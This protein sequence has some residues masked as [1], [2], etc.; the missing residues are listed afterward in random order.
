MRS[1]RGRSRQGL[2]LAAAG[3]ADGMRSSGPVHV[4]AMIDRKDCYDVLELIDLVNDPKVAPSGAVLAFQIESEGAPDTLRGLRQA[5]VHQ[6][7]ASSRDLLGQAIERSEGPR[8]PLDVQCLRCHRF[9]MRSR[10]SSRDRRAVRPAARSS[11]PSRIAAV[12]AGLLRISSVSSN[13]G[14]QIVD[15][16]HHRSRLP[17]LRDD[18]PSV[19]AVERV[20][21]LR[22]SVLHVSE[23]QMLTKRHGQKYGHCFARC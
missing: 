15:V 2:Q 11:A 3:W 12:G 13:Q 19:L 1:I 4:A 7:D 8:R 16:E 10:A 21:D 5:A 17:V 20:N 18:D 22:Q 6:L 23:G 9:A 14:L